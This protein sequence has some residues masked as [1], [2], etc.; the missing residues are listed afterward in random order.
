MNKEI[1]SDLERQR[2][3]LA[4]DRDNLDDC[5]MQQPEVYY[6]VAQA[7]ALANADRDACKLDLEELQAQLDQDI[8]AEALRKDEKLTE[9]SLQNRLKTL[10][11][12]Q[13]IQRVLLKKRQ[14]A[15]SWQMLKEAFQQ[16]SYM[17]KEIV[18]LFIAQRHDLALEGGVGQAR[19]SLTADK[20]DQNRVA[21]GALRRV[22]RSM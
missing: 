17:L 6:S 1:V 16:R 8:R 15:E 2:A 5:L 12:M 21:A 3:Y 22:K 13:D 14:E 18:A 10:P 4:I 19:A 11:K 20:A 7:L 9:T